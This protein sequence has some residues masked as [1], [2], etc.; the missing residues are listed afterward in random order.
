MKPQLA[1]RVRL[2]R[3]KSG[4][5]QKELA[6]IIGTLGPVGVSRHERSTALP[7]FLIAVGYEV[8]FH[9]PLAELFPGVY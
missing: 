6:F 7:R 1:S 9:V 5:S 3:R 8:V 2:H 4:L